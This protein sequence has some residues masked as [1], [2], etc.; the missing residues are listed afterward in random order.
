MALQ[1]PDFDHLRRSV[2]AFRRSSLGIMG[3]NIMGV[4]IGNIGFAAP[5]GLYRGRRRR[6]GGRFSRRFALLG[7]RIGN[8]AFASSGLG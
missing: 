8:S 2:S 5:G 1:R 7:A 4:S 6:F 3:V